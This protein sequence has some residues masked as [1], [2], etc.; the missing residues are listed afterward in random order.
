MVSVGVTLAAAR[1]YCALLYDLAL[2]VSGHIK[3]LRSRYISHPPVNNTSRERDTKKANR[4]RK[5]TGS[6]RGQQTGGEAVTMNR[7]TGPDDL[8][9]R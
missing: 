6:S 9:R 3:G 7:L 5:S 2:F 4:E 8:W 1:V